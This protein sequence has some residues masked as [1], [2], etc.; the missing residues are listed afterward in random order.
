MLNTARSSLLVFSFSLFIFTMPTP[1]NAGPFEENAPCWGQK[2]SQKFSAQQTNQSSCSQN[3]TCP[4]GGSQQACSGFSYQ[5]N[6][7][8]PKAGSY[9]MKDGGQLTVDTD[10]TKHFRGADGSEKIMRPDGSGLWRRA[11]GSQIEKFADG[12]KV[13]RGAD[14]QERTMAPGTCQ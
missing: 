11:D 5:Q 10:G 13:F 7:W 8:T 12:R 9:P 2:Q 4:K 3:P 6:S 1:A 14:G